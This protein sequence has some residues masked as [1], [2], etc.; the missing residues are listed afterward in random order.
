MLDVMPHQLMVRALED[1]RIEETT[2]RPRHFTLWSPSSAVKPP[3]RNSVRSFISNSV[4]KTRWLLERI[5]ELHKTPMI[6][7]VL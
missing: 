5:W 7:S 4:L 1:G 2:V 6:F 3:E